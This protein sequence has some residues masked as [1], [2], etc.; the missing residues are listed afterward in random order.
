[1]NDMTFVKE[2]YSEDT[3]GGF[4]C[5]VIVLADDTVLVIGEDS[6]VLYKDIATWEEL[7]ADSQIGTILRP[8]HERAD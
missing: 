8:V 3:G 6:V 7:S 1:M 4:V 2:A 5:D